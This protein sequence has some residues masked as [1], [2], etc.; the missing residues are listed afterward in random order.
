VSTSVYFADGQ[1]AAADEV[2]SVLG[3]PATSVKAMDA[4]IRQA[5]GASADVVVVVGSDQ[6]S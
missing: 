2:A 1:R 5:G 6:I 3:L 4:T